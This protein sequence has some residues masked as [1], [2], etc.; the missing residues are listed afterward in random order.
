MSNQIKIF[1]H[2]Q[3]EEINQYLSQNEVKEILTTATRIIIV[4]EV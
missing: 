3:E 4:K 1:Q 2:T